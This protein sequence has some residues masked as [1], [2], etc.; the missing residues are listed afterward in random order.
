MLPCSLT[1]TCELYE[2]IVFRW[3]PQQILARINFLATLQMGEI[4]KLRKDRTHRS[5][6]REVNGGL[7]VVSVRAGSNFSFIGR[8]SKAPGD[9]MTSPRSHN[10]ITVFLELVLQSPNSQSRFPQYTKK[11]RLQGIKK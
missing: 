6:Q 7:S 5:G 10:L 4:N 9:G 8:E 11:K 1:T 2:D 3:L